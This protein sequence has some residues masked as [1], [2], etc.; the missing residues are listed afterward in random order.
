MSSLEDRQAVTG[1][2]HLPAHLDELLDKAPT[3]RAHVLRARLKTELPV[4]QDRLTRLYGFTENFSNWL[5]QVV[6]QA[7]QLALARPDDLWALDLQRAAQPNWHLNGSL[8]YCAYT[9]KFAGNLSGVRQRISHLQELGVTYLHLL[10]FL[11]PG[12]PPNDGGFAVASY[13]EVDPALGT[14]QDLQELT[15]A[16]RAASGCAHRAPVRGRSGQDRSGGSS[17]QR[18]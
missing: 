1:Q 7:V 15:Q 14:N 3:A 13:D 5:N 2:A 17:A 12:T 11:K 6:A 16:L 18:Q 10:P 8:G 9:D 4:L